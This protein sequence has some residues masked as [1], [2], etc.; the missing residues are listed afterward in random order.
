MQ[1]L[2]LEVIVRGR[3][4]RIARVYNE[5]YDFVEDPES[6][7]DG[8]GAAGLRADIFSF[9]Q[10]PHEVEPKYQYHSEV[11]PIS[12]LPISTY[13]H[14]LKKQINDKTRN[15]VRKASKSGIELRPVALND[16]FIDGVV[17]IYNESDVRQGKRF[18]HFGMDFQAVKLHLDTFTNRSQF[19]GAYDGS[20]LIGFFKLTRNKNSASVMQIISR[21]S[22]RNKAPNNALLAKAVEMC[23][24]QGI[25]FLQYG[26]WSR[27]GLGD[28]KVKHG[29]VQFAVPRYYVPLTPLGR[30]ATRFR[31]YQKP[32]QFLP[33]GLR[34]RLLTL[35]DSWYSSKQA[36]F[37]LRTGQ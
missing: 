20:E 16:D 2:D 36:K 14:W 37:Q 7:L 22:H 15:M 5:W 8:L 28:Y 25:P 23:A 6:F 4:I 24:E 35:R 30:F 10:E 3:I 17:K 19:V 9:L 13:D 34:S 27:G 11:D 1:V 21:I 12:I 31:L 32:S 18:W 29:F 26:I 33:D